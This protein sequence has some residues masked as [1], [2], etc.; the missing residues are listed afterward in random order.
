M[1]YFTSRI[2]QDVSSGGPFNICRRVSGSAILIAN[3][4]MRDRMGERE[5][6]AEKERLLINGAQF[7]KRRRVLTREYLMVQILT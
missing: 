2:R 4:E 5:V 1:L 7:I 6:G 3:A